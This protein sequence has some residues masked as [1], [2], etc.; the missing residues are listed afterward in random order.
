MKR[1]SVSVPGIHLLLVGVVSFAWLVVLFR[2]APAQVQIGVQA[3]M[4]LVLGAY[5][6]IQIVRGRNGAAAPPTDV[7]PNDDGS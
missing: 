6:G 5:F 1:L 2:P 4:M 3:A 7:V